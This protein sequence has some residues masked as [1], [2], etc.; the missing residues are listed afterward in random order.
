[1]ISF[2]WRDEADGPITGLDASCPSGGTCQSAGAQTVAP[3]PKEDTYMSPLGQF[4]NHSHV[5]LCSGA[6]EENSSYLFR[7]KTGV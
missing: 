1:M 6:A 4:Q 5:V 2:R 3:D 7:H